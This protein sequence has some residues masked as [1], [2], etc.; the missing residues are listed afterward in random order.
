MAKKVIGID[1][2]SREIKA[3]TMSGGRGRAAVVRAERFQLPASGDLK[4]ALEAATPWLRQFLAGQSGALVVASVPPGEAVVKILDLPPSSGTTLDELLKFEAEHSIPFAADQALMDH[5]TLKMTADST[6]VLLACAR[7]EVVQQ[8]SE[9]LRAAGVKSKRVTLGAPA[10]LGL[11]VL[12]PTPGT[13]TQQVTAVVDVDSDSAEIVLAEGG[14]LR[15]SR[16]VR[17]SAGNG[18]NGNLRLTEAALEVRRTVQAHRAAHRGATLGRVLLCGSGSANEAALKLL[19]SEL[20]APVSR[21]DPWVGLLVAGPVAQVPI[22]ERSAYAAATGLAL[23]GLGRGLQ[24]NLIPEQ[25]RSTM[26]PATRHAIMRISG[27]LVAALSLIVWLATNPFSP[28]STSNQVQNS[29]NDVRAQLTGKKLIVKAGQTDSTRNAD[30]L[31]S[32]TDEIQRDSV[33]W[34]E[35]LRLLSERM[36]ESIKLTELSMEKGQ[37]VVIRGSANNSINV[38]EALNAIQT[39]PMFIDARPS[40]S[41]STTVANQPRSDF[42]IIATLEPLPG[43]KGGARRR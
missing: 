11:P 26:S 20:Q 39:M 14:A 1:I 33:L 28:L 42:E 3:V 12:Q 15:V 2:G 4:S 30:A 41:N 8:I 23:Q 31:R 35:V 40:Y 18:A 6:T 17:L 19:E 29:L 27:F 16:S 10:R 24:L 32:L 36:P 37:S 34:L 22:N 7:R 38:A 25:D 43:S 5:A 9:C 13:P 21:I